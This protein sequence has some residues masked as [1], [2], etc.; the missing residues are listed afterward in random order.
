AGKSTLLKA[1]L[2]MVPRASGTVR[3]IGQ[4]L[5]AVRHRVGYM[6]QRASLDWD[7]PTSVLD[8]VLMGL[9]GRLGWFMRPGRAEREE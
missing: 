4:P 2:G 7:F 8:V 9:Y 6:P 5:Q 1:V 3:F